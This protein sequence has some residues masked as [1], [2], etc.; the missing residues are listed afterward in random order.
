MWKKLG[1]MFGGAM[2]ASFESDCNDLDVIFTLSVETL[3]TDGGDLTDAQ[4]K[5]VW[6]LMQQQYDGTKDSIIHVLDMFRDTIGDTKY[7][8]LIIKEWRHKR[9]DGKYFDRAFDQWYSCI[10]SIE[11]K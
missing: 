8:K 5:P 11:G 1:A 3:S 4:G 6:E 9:N 10:S 7:K 2:T